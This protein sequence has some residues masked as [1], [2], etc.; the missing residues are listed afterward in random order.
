MG[1]TGY[2]VGSRTYDPRVIGELL[3]SLVASAWAPED[4]PRAELFPEEEAI[5]AR[6]VER[7]RRAFATTRACARRA[8]AELGVEPCAVLRGERGE[9]L[10]PDGIVGSMTHCDG[11]RGAAV[12]S[13]SDLASLGI[14]AEPHG[15]LSERVVR[16]IALPEEQRQL[17]ELAAADAS[18]HWDRLLFCAKEATY[19]AW[20]P[21]A[22]RWLGFGDARVTIDRGGGFVSELLVDGPVTG[23][24]GRWLA[25]EGLV[26]T[27]IAVPAGA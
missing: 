8:L 17:R 3:P 15:P 20:Y 6:A 4:D 5:V 2:E 9:P 14:D 18:L 19:K 21:L 27:A 10:W 13:S 25:R 23:F 24:E 11:Y 1:R 22:R 12:A 7:R 16:R 26:L